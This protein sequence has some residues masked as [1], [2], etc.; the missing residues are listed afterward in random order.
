MVNKKRL[1]L[2]KVTN[3]VE[4]PDCENNVEIN[5]KSMDM[6]KPVKLQCLGCKTVIWGII[7]FNQTFQITSVIPYREFDWNDFPSPHFFIHVKRW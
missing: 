5:I 4:C 6:E 3:Y 7:E 2:R 1:I